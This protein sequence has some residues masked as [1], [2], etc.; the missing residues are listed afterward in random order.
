MRRKQLL[1]VAL[2]LPSLSATYGLD[3]AQWV[4]QRGG[5][6][7]TDP[8]SRITGVK[9]GFRWLTDPD[10]EMIAGLKDLRKLDLSF[11]LITDAGMERLKL[12][13]SVTDLNLFA[14]EKITDVGISYIRG[15]KKLE[16]L[17]LHGT[18]V[19]DISMIQ[20]IPVLT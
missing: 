14:V 20:V 8:K 16:R 9:L 3:V 12:L 10:V 5:V 18:D 7:E 13:D 2:I 19:T 1:R 6:V 17:N 4:A 11:S 15:W